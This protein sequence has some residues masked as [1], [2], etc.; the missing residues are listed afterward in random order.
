MPTI[1]QKPAAIQ[2]RKDPQKEV[3][4]LVPLLQATIDLVSYD[5]STPPSR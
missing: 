3:I 5:F 2:P 4:D 1:I